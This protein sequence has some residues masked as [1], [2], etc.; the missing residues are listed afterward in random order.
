MMKRMSTS[1]GLTLGKS[2]NKTK[3]SECWAS[4]VSCQSTLTRPVDFSA[5]T[6]CVKVACHQRA[7]E[8]ERWMTPLNFL[9]IHVFFRWVSLGFL[10]D[11]KIFFFPVH[12]S[13]GLYRS[14]FAWTS[15]EFKC[16]GLL[17][18]FPEQGS[19]ISWCHGWPRELWG[20]SL[21]LAEIINNTTKKRWTKVLL[22]Y[23]ISS[24][25]DELFRWC[26]HNIHNVTRQTSLA[27]LKRRFHHFPRKEKKNNNKRTVGLCQTSSTSSLSF[28][29]SFQIGQKSIFKYIKGTC[30]GCY[31]PL[32]TFYWTDRRNI[33]MSDGQRGEIEEK[34]LLLPGLGS[35]SPLPPPPFCCIR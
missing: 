16:K 21:A 4:C 13:I 3:S 2:W 27:R 14:V 30:G 34:V 22:L 23:N 7:K 26:V 10:F 12:L 31:T 33:W 32:F 18:S 20:G 8:E 28:S 9:L 5:D 17:I 19:R 35:L 25:D 11:I 15:D 29:F 24:V 6:W 1:A